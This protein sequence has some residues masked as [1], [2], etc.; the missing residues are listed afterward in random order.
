MILFELDGVTKDYGVGEFKTNVLKDISFKINKGEFVS[1]MGPSGSGKSTI[2]HILGFLSEHTSGIYR[3]NNKQFSE[4]SDN[5]IAKVR[6]EEMGF[7][8]QSFNLLGRNSVY[9]NVR[10]PLLYSNRP[11]KEWSNRI[12]KAVDQV[13]LSHR[14]NYETAKLSGGEKQRTAIARALVNDPGVIFADEPT[15]NLD[16]VTGKSVMEIFQNLHSEQGHTVILI[17]HEASTA[18]Y[19]ER[20]IKILDGRVEEDFIVEDRLLKNSKYQK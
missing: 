17:T 6:N 12:E 18:K 9:E 5:E 3:F 16:S 2:L 4:Y 11:E 20:T 7:V 8:F 13:G 19:A 1:I 10:L 15:G 14:I